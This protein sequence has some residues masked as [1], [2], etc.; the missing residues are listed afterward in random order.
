[1]TGATGDAGG[2]DGDAATLFYPNVG[3]AIPAGTKAAT[4]VVRAVS[5]IAASWSSRDVTPVDATALQTML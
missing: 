2:R 5:F 3:V 4:S 1:M